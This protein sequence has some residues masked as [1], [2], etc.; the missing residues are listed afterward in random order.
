MVHVESVA[1]GTNKRGRVTQLDVTF[2]G[3][4]NAT[5]AEKA[6]FYRLGYPNRAGVL[7]AGNTGGVRVRSAKYDTATDRV[8]LTL[9][10]PL[11]LQ[12]KVLDLV[13]EGTSPAGL[14][15]VVGRYLDG[16]GNGQTG[17]NA[18]VSISKGGVS[19]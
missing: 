2:S 4:L 9:N 10:R 13:I 1:L 8:T 14:Q 3:P 19:I 5:Q 12:A 16:A 15:D 7:R 18:V 17:S 11:A 6:K